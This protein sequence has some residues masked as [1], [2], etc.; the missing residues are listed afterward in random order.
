MKCKIFLFINLFSFFISFTSLAFSEIEIIDEIEKHWNNTQTMSGNFFQI[1]SDQTMTQGKFFLSKPFKS[2]FIY[3]DS[4]D[5]VITNKSMI[6][7]VDDEGY[8]IDS[9]PLINSPLKDFLA[10]NVNFKEH[11]SQIKTSE[12][13]KHYLITVQDINENKKVNFTFNKDSLDLKKWEII[14][15]FGQS[16]VLEF[17]KI[18]KNIFI[19]PEIYTVKYKNN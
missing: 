1:N 5:T 12:D 16:T 19:S 18:K 14:D 2:K 10:E 11:D 8:R 13:L 17:T 15:E 9:Y 4:N 7:I 6:I 3:K